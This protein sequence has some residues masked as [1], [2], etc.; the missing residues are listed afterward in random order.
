MQKPNYYAVIPAEVRYNK[1]LTPNSKLLY[2]EITALCNM[3][4][5]CTASTE[6]FCKLYEVSRVS[7][8]KWLKT[9]EDNGY[10]KRVNIYKQGSKEILT[11]VITLVNM[12]SKE[13]FTDNTNTNITNTNLTDSNKKAR[14][15]KPTLDE[16]KNYCILRKNNIDAEAFIAFYESKGWMVGSNKMKN[17]KQAIIT[18]EKR[19]TKTPQ[20]MSKIHQHLQKN[21]NVKE[22]LK[23]QLKNEVN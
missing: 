4:G 12:P 7:I 13:K 14:F 23:Q 21:L 20:T 3:N 10:I 6:Y 16:V 8:Q 17:W 15:K 19:E 5:K 9:L 18:W 1:K 11:R 22:K 2:A